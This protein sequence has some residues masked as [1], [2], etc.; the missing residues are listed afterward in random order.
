MTTRKQV[1]KKGKQPMNQPRKSVLESA[2]RKQREQKSNGYCFF[3]FP[4]KK[5]EKTQRKTRITTVT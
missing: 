5:K 3:F 2:T 1:L 4:V